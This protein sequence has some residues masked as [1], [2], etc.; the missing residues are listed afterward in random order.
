MAEKNTAEVLALQA[1]MYA[2]GELAEPERAAFEERLAADQ[3]AREA[4]AE[5]VYMNAAL[6]GEAARPDPGYRAR[7]RQRLRPSWWKRLLA[8]QSY[9]G[10]PLL[11]SAVGAAAALLIALYVPRPE[12]EV[13][14]IVRE[15]PAELPPAGEGNTADAS[16]HDIS[17]IWAEL[18]TPDHTVR[19]HAEENQ[20]KTRQ[21]D[22]RH[23]RRNAR[24]PAVRQ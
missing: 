1:H 5:A 22:R 23:T 18:S 2:S 4:L 16:L 3:S 10:H 15:V 20:R 9:R 19:A 17:Y 13:R 7:V 14:V 8:R 6:R 12:P 24:P 21:E 11:W